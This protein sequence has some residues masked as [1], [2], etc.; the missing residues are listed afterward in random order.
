MAA[1]N[2]DEFSDLPIS[3]QRRYQLRKRRDGKCIRCGVAAV[4]ANFCDE[5][6]HRFNVMVREHKRRRRGYVR[7][8]FNS[9]SYR[10]E[11]AV[12]Q[13]ERAQQ[14]AFFTWLRISEPQFPSLKRFFAIPSEGLLDGTIAAELMNPGIRR[15]VLDT[16]LPVPRRGFHG[17]WIEFKAGDETLTPEQSDW[18]LFLEEEGYEVHIVRDWIEAARITL[19]YLGF[20]A[21]IP[22]E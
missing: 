13:P 19:V 14:M 18:K 8:N 11:S 22:G 7:R 10:Y 9:E 6:R 2:K 17:L 5:H 15:G 1:P 21:A 20:S 4:D 12:K 3:R 16:F